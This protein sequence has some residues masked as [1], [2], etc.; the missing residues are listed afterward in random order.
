MTVRS[1]RVKTLSSWR[2]TLLD[3]L[4]ITLLRQSLL[5]WA[6]SFAV[7]C[8]KKVWERDPDPHINPCRKW[9]WLSD[10]RPR[11]VSEERGGF[12]QCLMIQQAFCFKRTDTLMVAEVLSVMEAAYF[13]G[14]P[15]WPAR[16]SVDIATL[17][18]IPMES[19]WPRPFPEL[20]SKSSS[21]SMRPILRTAKSSLTICENL[22]LKSKR[23][24]SIG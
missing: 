22:L 21:T 19:V 2:G 24:R 4:Y 15:Q 6:G 9:A 17:Q 5:K 14:R 3:H 7:I 13:C 20:T 18:I 11:L 8:K 10:R 16:L 12:R 1:G 23:W